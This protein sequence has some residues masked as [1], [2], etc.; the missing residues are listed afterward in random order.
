MQKKK[1]P[2]TPG[3]KESAP[4]VFIPVRRLSPS[5]HIKVLEKATVLTGLNAICSRDPSILESKIPT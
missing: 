2:H 3:G 4:M 1:K 5:F